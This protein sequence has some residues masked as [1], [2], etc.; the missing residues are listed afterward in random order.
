MTSFKALLKHMD[1]DPTGHPWIRKLL[2]A[3]QLVSQRQGLDLDVDKWLK[4]LE[5]KNKRL[6]RMSVA[7]CRFGTRRTALPDRKSQFVGFG[8]QPGVLIVICGRRPKDCWLRTFGISVWKIALP[9]FTGLLGL[10]E[11]KLPFDT[12]HF[13][14]GT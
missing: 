11:T 6:G 9:Q 1:K 14:R 13:S 10:I 12:A 4:H 3:N 2:W 8:A 7:T 5:T